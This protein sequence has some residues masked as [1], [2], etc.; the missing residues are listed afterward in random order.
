MT[1]TE[2]IFDLKIHSFI[3]SPCKFPAITLFI[4]KTP[5]TAAAETNSSLIDAANAI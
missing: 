4:K 3:K 1:E 2:K 5:N